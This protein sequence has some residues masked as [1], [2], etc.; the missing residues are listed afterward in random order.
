LDT[1]PQLSNTL[2]PSEHCLNYAVL[3]ETASENSGFQSIL[4][5]TSKL[6]NV[7]L[8]SLA[9]DTEC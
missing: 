1:Y 4:K 7:Y 5:Q 2:R 6:Q 8:P 9:L 3:G